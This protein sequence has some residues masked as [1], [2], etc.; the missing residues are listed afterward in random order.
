MDINNN[1][2]TYIA[3]NQL[4]NASD[5][6]AS[7]NECENWCDLDNIHSKKPNYLDPCSDWDY[8]QTH[9]VVHISI[10]KNGIFAIAYVWM[11]HMF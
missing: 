2:K 9:K 5:P 10:F 1:E 11:G 4:E 3:L 8:V 6:I 7:L